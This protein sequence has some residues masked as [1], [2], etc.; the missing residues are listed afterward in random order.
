MEVLL[1]IVFGVLVG[2][3]LGLVGGGGSILTVPILV[4]ALGE[5]VH[6][7]T[8]TAL[9]IVG[10][11]A[12]IGAWDHRRAGRVHMPVALTFGGIG[13]IGALAGSW[14]NHLAPAR[15]VLVGFAILMLA[16]AV[17]MVTLR[18]SDRPP[19]ARF[20]LSPRVVAA[21]LAVGV[22]TG[23]FG[24][25]GGFL[26]VPALVLAVGLPMREAVGTSLVVI[27]INAAAA[28]AGHLHFGGVDLTVTLLFII[29]GAAGTILGSRLSG[30]IDE[31][32][33]RQGFAG[34]IVLVA[35]YMLART[36]LGAGA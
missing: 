28:L 1:T 11:N 13:I 31:K 29:G 36:F 24:V 26:V 18:L 35:C 17:A 14:L 9:A 22:L 15:A 30:R 19:R 7:A 32:R 21:G 34:M 12:L 5:S 20:H 16:A 23:F 4:Y 27:A 33:L 25:G 3:S 10:A 2:L 6:L 8:G